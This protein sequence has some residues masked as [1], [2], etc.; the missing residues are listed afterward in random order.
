MK[1]QLQ[2]LLLVMSSLPVLV[3]AQKAVN[4]TGNTLKAGAITYAYSVGEVIGFSITSNCAY[5][6]GVIQPAKYSFIP[7][8]YFFFDNLHQILLYPNPARDVIIVETNYPDIGTYQITAFDGRV[9]ETGKYTYLPINITRLPS[10]IYTLTLFS[11]DYK[12]KETFKI[13]KL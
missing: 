7:G 9:V 10:G 4:V 11:S 13:M 3:R 2:I 8:S 12:L 1:K 5:T 6:P